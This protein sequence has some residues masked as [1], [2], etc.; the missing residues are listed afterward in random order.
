MFRI[1][2]SDS[3][4][5]EGLAPLRKSEH[6]E[7]VQ[8]KA[9]EAEERLHEFDA[10]LV[11]S[12][13]KVT[14]DLLVKMPNLKIVGRAG[15]GVDN[16]DVEAATRHGVV[17]INA[18]NGNT[19]ST[20]EHTFAMMAALVRHIP[21]AHVSV[22]SREWNRS[23]F[24]GSELHG[25]HLG[26]VG[27][28][29]I[30]SEVAKRARAFGMNVHVYDPFLTKERAEKLGV[31]ICSL[32]EVLALSDII[33]VH[34]PLTKETKGLLGE[35]NLAKTKKG[36]YLLNCARG[37]II[38][39]QAL[40]KF[41]ENGHVAGAALDVFEQEPPGDHPL[42][43]FDNVIVTPHLG[44][45]TI[46]AQLNVATQVAEEVLQFLN[47]KPVTSSINLPTL[48]K[49]LYEKIQSF[50]TLAK[51]MGMIASQYMN[52]PV[53]EITVTYA[54]T[55]AD[56]ETTYI[57]R[58]LLAGFLKPR[59]AS[60]VNEVNAAMIA[61]E[62]G[63]TFGEKFS[64]QT[65]GYA[66]CISL[67]V[68]GENKTFTIMGTHIPNYGN[69]IVYFDGFSIDFAPEGHLLYIQ[70]QD[71]PGMIGKVGNVL[72]SHHANIATMQVGR[73]QAGGRAIMM[74]SLD[75]PLDDELLEKLVDIEDIESA[76][77]LEL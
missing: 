35:K 54:G 38:D 68:Y 41:L 48:S 13:T 59:V 36:V 53:Q 49:D 6:I 76:K 3:I 25:K 73:Q 11:R 61:K 43:S 22:K 14:E 58:S 18:P 63:I 65:H 70:H 55:V 64:D 4:S 75:K 33:T 60:T 69:R 39:E 9:T 23:A 20:A 5:E 7:V 56:L 67:T 44:A 74:L 26:I 66:N 32:D 21:Q 37:G 17:V 46:E 51:K 42:L 12:A 71:K 15:V 77:K 28:G 8:K 47:G 52:L 10:L 29:R 72:G 1:L 19:I 62:R 57:T 45:S 2:V 50:Y 34:T 24:V 30:G 27:F 16:I 31:S 40:V